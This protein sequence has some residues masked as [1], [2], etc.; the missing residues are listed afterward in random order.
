M[1]A[2]APVLAGAKVQQIQATPEPAKSTDSETSRTLAGAQLSGPVAD[3]PLIS[4]STP[5]Y[6]E[7]AKREGVEGTTKIYFIVLPDGRVK[8][9]IVIEKTSGFEDFDRNAA[10]ALLAWRFQPLAGSQ[11]GEQWGRIAFH[12]RLS[13]I[14]SN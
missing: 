13:G 14:A 6:P 1:R 12:Y 2:S 8:E 7:W 5:V 4:Y 9:N 3:R 11:T 10:Q